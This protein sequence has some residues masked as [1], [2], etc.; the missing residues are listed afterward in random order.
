MCYACACALC[1]LALR[2]GHYGVIAGSS[3]G[4]P[5]VLWAI[6]VCRGAI[7]GLTL[8]YPLAILWACG[9]VR[10]PYCPCWYGLAFCC[11]SWAVGLAG[12]CWV[13]PGLSYG[14]H[15]AIYQSI[16]VR[17]WLALDC[18]VGHSWDCAGLRWVLSLS[19]ITILKGY[20]LCRSSCRPYSITSII[21]IL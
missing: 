20:L 15:K 13:V 18:V 17:L 9:R 21:I 3:T 14:Y 12:L 4:H 7:R 5:V 16:M 11:L 10:L 8:G 1:C 19:R 6:V 2:V